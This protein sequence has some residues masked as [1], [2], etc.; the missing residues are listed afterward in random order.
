MGEFITLRITPKIE[1]RTESQQSGT[2]D[3]LKGRFW[4]AV[5]RL[6]D[7]AGIPR[8]ASEST[9]ERESAFLRELGP[10]LERALIEN[11]K[12]EG[13]L[14]PGRVELAA[15]ITFRAKTLRYSS[16]LVDLF[17]APVEA[18]AKLGVTPNDFKPFFEALLPQAVDE[19]L[20]PG[21]GSNMSYEFE[22]YRGFTAA[23]SSSE[24]PSSSEASSLLQRPKWLWLLANGSLL[25]PVI[26]LIVIFFYGWRQTGAAHELQLNLMKEHLEADRKRQKDL[27]DPLLDHYLKLLKEDRDREEKLVKILDDQRKILNV[28]K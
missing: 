13:R 1:G 3:Q 2:P 24:N 12:K 23:L 4:E 11:M 18:L 26:L 16:V 25:L 28:W 21:V 17:V 8:K 6:R 27:V 19:V 20:G 14:F 10:A 22:N 15:S 7:N 9:D 5:S